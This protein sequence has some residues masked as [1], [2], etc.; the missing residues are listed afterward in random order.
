VYI[1]E[2][3]RNIENNVTKIRSLRKAFQEIMNR[4]DNQGYAHVANH[5]GYLDNLC[6]HGPTL[7][8]E[9]NLIH[10]FL[11]WHRAY[12]LKLERLLQERDPTVSVPWWDWRSETSRK[13]GIPKS[14]SRDKTGKK[15]NPLSKFYID[16]KGRDSAS[17]ENISLSR[18][19]TRNP[20]KPQEISLTQKAFVLNEQDIP[21]LFSLS[22][23]RQFSERLRI[24]WHNFI[25]VWIGGDMG[26]V[27]TAAYDPIFFIHHC[28]VDRIWAVWQTLHGVD[29]IPSQMRNVILEPFGMTVKDVLDINSL[30]Y[31]YA[32]V[33][34]S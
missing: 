29:S 18:Y 1:R 21:Q 9:G 16:I 19:T 14:F 33:S 24:G 27:N 31:D 13:I 5:H 34:T 28:N 11:P 15:A 10:K 26:V 12:L 25:H 23:F 4:A 32:S 17:Q 7:D 20:G 30:N 2:N 3:I 22:D 8:P 6:P